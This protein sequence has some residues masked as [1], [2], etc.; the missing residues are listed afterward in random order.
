MGRMRANGDL[1][2]STPGWSRRQEAPLCPFGSVHVLGRR[3]IGAALTLLLLLAIVAN[4]LAVLPASIW[5]RDEAHLGLAVARFDPA[6]ERPHAPWFPLWV[7]L[8]TLASPLADEPAGGLQLLSA[9]IGAWT[10]FPLAGLLSIWLRRDLAVAGALLYLL[11]P[12]P[13]LLAGRAYS[14]TP[15]TFLL[16]V[17]AAWWLR[18]E[19]RHRDTLSG[20]I[21]AALCLLVRPQL[22]LAVAALALWRG[23]AADRRGR[24]LVALPLGVAGAAALIGL[25][26]ASGG[27]TP[28]IRSLA[29]HARYHAEGLAAVNHGFAAS[30]LARALIRPEAAV[31]WIV[32][33][34]VGLLAWHR[35][36]RVVGSPWPLALAGIAPLSA[37]VFW[38][39]DPTQP[40][41]ALPLLALSV[42]LVVIGLAQLA[43]LWAHLAVAVAVM[44]SLA[45]GLPQAR[46]I[47]SSVS[48]VMEAIARAGDEAA[49]RGGVVVVD[50][51][52]LVFAE[53]AAESGR[54]RQPFVSDFSFEIGAAEP[55]PPARTVAVFDRGRGGF[56]AGRQRSET[57]R[58][59]I[60]WVRRLGPDRFL[61]VTVASGATVVR[62]PTSW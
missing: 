5:D 6:A 16:L 27:V 4:R 28:L 13:W 47:R 43:G 9:L 10:L 58:C 26:G 42:P 20:S 48:P 17:A 46:V 37:T 12:G 41:Y 14:D 52:L 56:V 18:S 61:E 54:L 25:V 15:A 34:A 60:P 38:L 23:L 30:G 35:R 19:S 36:R 22:V 29:A 40:R 21:A 3:R 8:G 39:S 57:F 7:G 31:A 62:S 53:Y 2:A 59:T 24:V 50:R 45:G 33:G 51:T 11:L 55:P 1:D 49:A 32:L 44:V